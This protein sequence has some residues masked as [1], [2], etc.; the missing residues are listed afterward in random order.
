MGKK[1]KSKVQFQN[2]VVELAD[3]QQVTPVPSQ[4]VPEDST[5][6]AI[7]KALLATPEVAQ[8]KA[9]NE[10]KSKIRE[11]NFEIAALE[12]E[13]K[14]YLDNKASLLRELGDLEKASGRNAEGAINLKAVA[15]NKAL[16]NKNIID[17]RAMAHK[18]FQ[19][20]LDTVVK[21]ALASDARYLE[22]EAEGQNIMKHAEKLNKQMARAELAVARIES[23]INRLSAEV[24]KLNAVANSI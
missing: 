18:S 17:M 23:K 3:L 22:L 10:A 21:A 6:D 2:R 20:I 7:V 19:A 15:K 8:I 1:S 24:A 4:F 5:V 14:E 11:L 16:Q 12:R 9:S 13:K